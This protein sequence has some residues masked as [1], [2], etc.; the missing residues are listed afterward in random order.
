[1]LKTR[2]ATCTRDVTVQYLR[3]VNSPAGGTVNAAA[4]PR[5]A[6]KVKLGTDSPSRDQQSP[7]AAS[8][9]PGTKAGVKP[10]KTESPPARDGHVR[11]LMVAAAAH[12]RNQKQGSPRTPS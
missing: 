9:S 2:P 5:L 12:R 6:L 3:D 1:V 8:S 11:D 4:K 7:V 10:N